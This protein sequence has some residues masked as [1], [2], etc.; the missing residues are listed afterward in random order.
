MEF[1]ITIQQQ[2]LLCVYP[3]STTKLKAAEQ[4][5]YPLAPSARQSINPLISAVEIVEEEYDDHG[6]VHDD[7]RMNLLVP[8]ER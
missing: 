7:E 6:D 1:Q 5:P 8:N 2:P 4:L 3:Q